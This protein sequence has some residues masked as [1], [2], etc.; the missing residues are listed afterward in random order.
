MIRSSG[1][2][3]KLTTLVR[4]GQIFLAFNFLVRIYFLWDTNKVPTV[5]EYESVFPFLRFVNEGPK[6][7]S[8]GPVKSTSD[9]YTGK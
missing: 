6:D 5:V 7:C 2:G 9:S 8:H 3:H 1:D 4:G